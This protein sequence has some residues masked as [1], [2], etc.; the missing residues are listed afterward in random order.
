MYLEQWRKKYEKAELHFFFLKDRKGKFNIWTML[1]KIE[2]SISNHHLCLHKDPLL[3]NIPLTPFFLLCSSMS[4]SV[5]LAVTVVRKCTQHIS[6]IFHKNFSCSLTV[7]MFHPC[8][9]NSQ[10]NLLHSCQFTIFKI[11]KHVLFPPRSLSVNFFYL[12]VV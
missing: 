7:M 2:R 10:N 3:L 8:F 5:T 6:N 4:S 1:Q 11:H 9:S 12:N